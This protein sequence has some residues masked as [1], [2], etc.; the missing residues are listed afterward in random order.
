MAQV[1][2]NIAGHLKHPRTAVRPT[3]NGWVVCFTFAVPDRTIAGVEHMHSVVSTKRQTQHV[4]IRPG[5]I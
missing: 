5:M 2:V 4:L 3:G 1:S